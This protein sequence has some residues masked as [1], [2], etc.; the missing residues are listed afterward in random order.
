MLGHNGHWPLKTGGGARR[1]EY[2]GQSDMAGLTLHN[3][4]A[5]LEKVIKEYC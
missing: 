5:K 4:R 3:F 1:P 2:Q